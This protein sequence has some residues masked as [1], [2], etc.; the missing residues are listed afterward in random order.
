MRSASA[1]ERTRVALG[2]VD[3]DQSSAVDGGDQVGRALR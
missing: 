3:D 2:G 1:A